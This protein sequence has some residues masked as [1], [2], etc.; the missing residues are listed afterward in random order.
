MSIK[1]LF[2]DLGGKKNMKHEILGLYLT[3]MVC[4]SGKEKLGL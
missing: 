4:C 2:N 1:T 3:N